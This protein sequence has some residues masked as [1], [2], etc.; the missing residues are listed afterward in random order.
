RLGSSG[1]GAGVTVAADGGVAAG[2]AVA[3]GFVAGGFGFSLGG[4][5]RG[6]SAPGGVNETWAALVA[7]HITQ[8]TIDSGRRIFISGAIP[9]RPR[10][11]RAFCYALGGSPAR[12]RSAPPPRRA[13]RPR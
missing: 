12:Y 11:F 3:A 10:F 7:V 1:A 2:F 9:V 5:A 6:V 8:N 13:D 4:W